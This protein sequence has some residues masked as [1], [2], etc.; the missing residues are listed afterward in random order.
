MSQKIVG[1]FSGQWENGFKQFDGQWGEN[2]QLAL[3]TLAMEPDKRVPSALVHIMDMGFM[4]KMTGHAKGDFRK[5]PDTVYME[6]QRL[7]GACMIDQYLA[8][9][10]MSMSETGYEEGTEKHATTGAEEVVLDGIK[11]DSPEAVV[12]HME[13]LVFP[14]LEKAIAETNPGDDAP[15]E[16]VVAGEVKMQ[17]TFGMNLLKAPYGNVQN[18]PYMRYWQYGYAN[19]FMAYRMYP[20]VMERDFSLQAD[21][22]GQ[23]Q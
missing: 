21:L 10:A 5:D 22:G 23:A 19:Y 11:I 6:F 12:E 3:R 7:M 16:A 13:R 14:A 2:A 18:F 9:N 4:E 8:A 1:Q 20:E 17:K 15:A